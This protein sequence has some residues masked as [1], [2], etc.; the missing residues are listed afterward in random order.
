[1]HSNMDLTSRA[2]IFVTLVWLL[3]FFSVLFVSVFI[4]WIHQGRNLF[5][6]VFCESTRCWW[7]RSIQLSTTKT[8]WIHTIYDSDIISLLT[9]ITHAI[10]MISQTNPF[11]C[12]FLIRLSIDCNAKTPLHNLVFSYWTCDKI[13]ANI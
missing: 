2:S 9:S 7:N 11:E 6:S 5:D 10:T 1:M 4:H 3:F 13:L 8:K 12:Q